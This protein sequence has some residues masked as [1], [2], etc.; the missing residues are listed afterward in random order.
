MTR[1]FLVALLGCGAQSTPQ[2]VTVTAPSSSTPQSHVA[3]PSSV[4]PFIDA[5]CVESQNELDCSKAKIDG[6]DACRFGLRKLD[7]K[8]DPP[9]IVAEC[10]ADMQKVPSGLY[11][12]GCK[13]RS[14]VIYFV[15][16]S[17][18]IVRIASAK[19]LASAF[20][21]VSS[22][23]EAVAFA[24]LESG[25]DPFDKE[26]KADDGKTMS[27][28]PLPDGDGWSFDLFRYQSCGCDHPITRVSYF[29]ARDGTVTERARARALENADQSGMCKD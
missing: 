8:L 28:S 1:L 25:D 24:R 9:A 13:L 17:H 16:T 23:E 12:S 10:H 20:A 4:K 27:T 2:T 22:G 15:A 7:V 26:R 18:G 6:V 11:T 3:M 19:D 29:V 14:S 5:G 21:P